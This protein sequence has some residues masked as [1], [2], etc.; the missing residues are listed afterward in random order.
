MHKTR[1]SMLVPVYNVEPYV[2]DCLR[3]LL[4]Q[5]VD[6]LEVIVINDGST[7]GSLRV[8][9]DTCAG[10]ARVR[11]VDKPNEGYGAT[12]NRGFAEARGEY[13]G[14]LESDDVL[15]PGALGLLLQAAEGADADVAKG[16][17]VYWW[18]SDESRTHR[19]W[20][21]CGDLCGTVVDTTCDLRIYSRRSTIWSAIYRASMLRDAHIRFLETPGAAFQDT[22]FNFKAFAASSRSVFVDAPIVR[23]RQDNAGSSIHSSSKA[24]AVSAEFDE[25]DRWL[26]ELPRGVR[27]PLLEE[28][29]RQRLNAYLWNLDRLDV[30]AG[31]AFLRSMCD[32]FGALASEGRIGP[33][34]LD[35]WRLTNLRAIRRNPERY[36]RLRRRYHGDSALA[37]ARFALALGGP[38]ALVRALR[39]RAARS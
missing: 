14:I 2:G 23:Y 30:P 20:E 28:S 13:V 31:V 37:K 17:F 27:E 34:T 15:E 7:D 22:S 21:V 11:I 24:M 39:E 1:L 26:G 16:D 35:A 33:A 3:S 29:V 18:P 19:A 8:V 5:D 25:V 9:R 12:L 38:L 36:L 10:D 4:D 32:E 6:G